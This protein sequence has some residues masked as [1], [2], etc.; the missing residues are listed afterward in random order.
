MPVREL[1]ISSAMPYEDG[2]IFGETGPYEIVRG[3]AHIALDPGAPANARV[4]DLSAAPRDADGTVAVTAD[5]VLLRP[6][7]PQ[8]GNGSLLYTVANRGGVQIPVGLGGSAAP[9][10]PTGAV[11]SG[12]G[13]VLREGWTLAW[14]GWQFDVPRSPGR[15]SIDLPDAVAADGTPI[16]GR[17]RV[18]LMPAAAV[19][20]LLLA[21][22]TASLAGVTEPVY[23]AA[24]LDQQD[25]VLTVRDTPD[26][27]RRI[28]PRERWRFARDQDG[29][30]CP[31]PG[32]V[33]LDDGFEPGLL[34]E[35]VYT[36][37]RCPVVGCGLAAVRDVVTYL[38]NR[39]GCERV[40][41]FG[42]SQSAR[43]LRQ[44][45]FEGLNLDEQGHH[46]FDGVL[47]HAAGARRG[48]F[49][50][51][52]AM[53][54]EG[55]APGFADLPPF[56]VGGAGNGL[57]DRQRRVGGVPK[58]ITVNTSWEYWRADAAL[59]HISPDGT[60]D[61]PEPDGTR[62]YLI[63]GSDHVGAIPGAASM[64]GLANPE[65]GLDHVP[66]LR[67]LL[68]A[69][70]AWLAEGTPPPPSRVPRLTD[71]TA[72]PREDVLRRLA[73]VP[74]L[75]Q[76]AAKALP[77]L[78]RLDL[79]SDADR[80]IGSYPPRFGEPYACLIPDVDDDG[81]ETAGILLPENAVPLA[82]RTGWNTPRLRPGG[83]RRFAALVGSRTPFPPVPDSA[84]PRP[85]ISERYRDRE[86]YQQRVTLAATALAD[87]R[88][89][90]Y[91][92]IAHVV[93]AA[94]RRYD[95][96]ATRRT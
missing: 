74:G 5:V 92:D 26:G 28:V 85:A 73:S 56:A 80:G 59:A 10:D 31:D 90:L 64:F 93:T 51:R 21:D 46:A 52:C 82:T 24:D 34:Y 75:K 23:P 18:Q 83:M 12:D 88:L 1:V 4:V 42:V 81:N 78:R 37:A 68:A 38:R 54:S 67:A 86:D 61:L 13:L 69:L 3:L 17:A 87:Q 32:H 70:H 66:V 77:R 57:L 65:N 35:V 76:P 39:E 41:G 49:N 71:G 53:P 14:S 96:D 48:E 43:F 8:R 89:L 2:A 47:C 44:L 19:R 11:P 36:T 91:G 63:S 60:A 72:V 9:P 16:R 58:L 55:F 62:H 7:D 84:D 22:W 27:Q 40:V 50:H 15:V 45:L 30:P 25:A 20:S 33:W 29:A 94:M 6:A 79:G 95:T